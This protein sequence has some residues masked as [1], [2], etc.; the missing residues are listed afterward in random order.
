[1]YEPLRYIRKS[2]WDDD[3]SPEHPFEEY[4]SLNDTSRVDTWSGDYL[5]DIPCVYLHPRTGEPVSLKDLIEVEKQIAEE[6]EKEHLA[7]REELRRWAQEKFPSVN[8]DAVIRFDRAAIARWRAG[9]SESP[10]TDETTAGYDTA[11]AA[12]ADGQ[13]GSEEGSSMT[14]ESS[15]TDTPFADSARDGREGCADESECQAAAPEQTIKQR[16]LCRQ[17]ASQ[18]PAHVSKQS[19]AAVHAQAPCEAAAL[20]EA[21]VTDSQFGSNLLTCQRTRAP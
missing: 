13:T 5:G 6:E 4:P 15:V 3:Y 19:A 18:S 17:S 16:G 20:V 8:L 9:E 1:M 2:V 21:T 14:G 7:R 12:P 11:E 10:A